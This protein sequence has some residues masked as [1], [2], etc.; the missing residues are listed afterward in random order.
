MMNRPRSN[1][2]KTRTPS[3]SR[4]PVSITANGKSDRL[5]TVKEVAQRL[6][7]SVR[8]VWSLRSRGQIPDPV[9]I[10]SL[11]RWRRS[12]IESYIRGLDAAGR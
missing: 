3:T 12:E 4:T 2:P 9:K 10:G 8:T 6:S 1:T 5:L 11:T 7:V